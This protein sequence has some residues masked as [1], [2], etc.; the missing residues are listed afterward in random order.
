[1]VQDV[2]WIET[3]KVYVVEASSA[4]VYYVSELDAV[5]VTGVDEM[6]VSVDVIDIYLG[7]LNVMYE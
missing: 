7:A 6:V 3:L 5:N 4:P 2:Y 1:M